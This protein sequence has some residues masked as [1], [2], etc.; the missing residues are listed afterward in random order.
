VL[1]CQPA[2]RSF[3]KQLFVWFRVVP[4]ALLIGAPAPNRDL[5]AISNWD[6]LNP[7]PH[8]QAKTGEHCRAYRQS[9]NLFSQLLEEKQT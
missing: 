4:S 7:A 9:W 5:R 8:K 1:L 6:S 3:C 2:L